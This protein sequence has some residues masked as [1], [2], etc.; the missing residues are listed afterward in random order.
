MYVT[1]YLKDSY[2][3]LNWNTY[4]CAILVWLFINNLVDAFFFHKYLYIF[5]YLKRVWM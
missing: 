1:Y 4:L 2:E 5:E 3:I